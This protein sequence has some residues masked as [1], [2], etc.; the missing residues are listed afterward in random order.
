[1]SSNANTLN[2]ICSYFYINIPKKL[3]GNNE[4]CKMLK[5]DIRSMF[6]QEKNYEIDF[7]HIIV[8]YW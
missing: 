2:V 6:L 3:S 1:M 7:D 5:I 4:K 8:K